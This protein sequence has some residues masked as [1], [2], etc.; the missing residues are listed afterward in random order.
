MVF[1]ATMDAWH[2][3]HPTP[4][5]RKQKWKE[6]AEACDFVYHQVGTKEIRNAARELVQYF[7]EY[8][9]KNIFKVH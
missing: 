5:A 6:I 2:V 7:Q 8:S 9:G 1:Y 3:K 4:K